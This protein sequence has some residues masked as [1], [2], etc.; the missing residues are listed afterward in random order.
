MT[1][2]VFD[3]LTMVI[4]PDKP[5]TL[6]MI[7]LSIERFVLF[8]TRHM[9]FQVQSGTVGELPQNCY[10][11]TLCSYAPV[12]STPT[13]PSAKRRK[14]L[15][16]SQPPAHPQALAPSSALLCTLIP[17]LA[18]PDFLVPEIYQYL[19]PPYEECKCLNMREIWK[20]DLDLQAFIVVRNR[21]FLMGFNGDATRENAVW[22]VAV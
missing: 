20:L 13:T 3:V 21:A 11:Y 1:M 6:Q 5:L 10:W 9:T 12:A 7:S 22:N 14:T 2:C 18:D 15:T 8:H 4:F 19:L 16:S 17:S